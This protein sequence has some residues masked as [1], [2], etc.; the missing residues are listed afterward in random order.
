[1]FKYRIGEVIHVNKERGWVAFESM[2]KVIEVIGRTRS[3]SSKYPSFKFW[4]SGREGVQCT[5]LSDIY[6]VH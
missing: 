3:G 4:V 1:M 6:W 5:E 2:E